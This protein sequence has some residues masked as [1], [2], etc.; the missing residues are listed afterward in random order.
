MIR[1]GI[2]G[3]SGFVGTHLYN[4]LGL[5]PEKFERISFED[6]FFT[7]SRKLSDFVSECD[8]IVHLAALNRHN[9]PVVIYETNIEL[10]KKLIAACETASVKPHIIIFFIDSGREG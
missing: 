6:S 2:T 4:T 1:V 7:D 9:D 8:V 3:Q 5:Y 10:V